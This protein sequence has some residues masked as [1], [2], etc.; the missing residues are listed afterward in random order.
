MSVKPM[1]LSQMVPTPAA[2]AMNTELTSPSNL[3]MVSRFG[4]PGKLTRDC[5]EVGNLGL[6]AH[7]QT[8]DLGPFRATGHAAAILSLQRVFVTVQKERP[9]LYKAV[10]TAGML[11]CRAVRGSKKNYSNHS[12]GTAIDLYFGS[13]IDAMGDNQTQRGLL[14]LYPFFHERKWFWGAG[15]GT[16]ED[17][18]HFEASTE[19]IDQW[20]RMGLI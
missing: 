17:S 7:I 9:D 4:K 8:A 6:K 10:R 19:L 14:E 5:S 2:S 3:F 12:W 13:E 18:M 11:C 20:D 1:S 15:F 16:R